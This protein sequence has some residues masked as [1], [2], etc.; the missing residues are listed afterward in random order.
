MPS[1]ELLS[2]RGDSFPFAPGS[3]FVRRFLMELMIVLFCSGCGIAIARPVI[4]VLKHFNV[5]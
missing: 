5:L 4:A 3:P 1:G 2:G